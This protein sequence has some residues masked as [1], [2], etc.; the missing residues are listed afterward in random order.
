MP[1]NILIVAETRDGAP[2]KVA[3]ELVTVAKQ[4]AQGMGG[5]IEVFA[6]GS[7]L[8]SAAQALAQAGVSKV[9]VADD[10]ALDASRFAPE[11]HAAVLADA[12]RAAQP[13][14]VLF[15]AT[16]VG[17]EISA[18][19]AAKLDWGL[20]TDCTDAKFENGALV[21]TKPVYAGKAIATVK[22]KSLPAMVS[23]RPNIFPPVEA[24][25]S[26]APVEIVAVKMVNVRAKVAERVKKAETAVDLS[27]AKIVVSGGRGVRGPEGFEPLHALAKVLGAAVGASRAAV[28]AGWVDYGT[29]VGQTG[30]TVSPQLYIA[31]GI[32]GAI[33]HLAGMSSSKNIVAINKDPDAPIFKVADY[34]IAGDLFEVVPALTEELKKVMAEK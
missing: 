31:C 19:A 18:R 15:G 7:N 24:N 30:K 34:G 25:A 2:R 28:D 23:V 8:A 11:L 3:F 9:Y 12:I 32:S 14:V 33:Q 5:K 10:A 6:M 27:E 4:L 17:K 21:L 29:Q 16:G 26:A 1:N 20:V 13:A 22:A